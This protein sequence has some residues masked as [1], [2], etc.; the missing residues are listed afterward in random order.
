M[1][2]LHQQASVR[3]KARPRHAKPLRPEIHP[4]RLPSGCAR[5]ADLRLR[6]VEQPETLTPT[7]CMSQWTGRMHSSGTSAV[8]EPSAFPPGLASASPA[9][10]TLRRRTADL[11]ERYAALGRSS[12]G[13]E[14]WRH[15]LCG[16]T[17][18]GQGSDDVLIACGGG[19]SI[20][21][22]DIRVVTGDT[23]LTPVIW[24]TQPAPDDGNAAIQRLGPRDPLATRY[25]NSWRSR[26]IGWVRRT[27]R[28][29]SRPGVGVAWRGGRP[30][31]RCSD[32][33]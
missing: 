8:G 11:L 7:T 31:K 6:I 5:P 32:A 16:A 17:E 10:R 23:D 29:R 3:T 21:P 1:P 12:A 30:A 15:G 2:R 33:R 25:R 20:D 14:R 28:V 26:R 9:R 13:S 22:N 27:P 19:A 24:S 18:I 4:T